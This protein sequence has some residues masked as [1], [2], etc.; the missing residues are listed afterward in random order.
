MLD[1][2]L[3]LTPEE[4]DATAALVGFNL[5]VPENVPRKKGVARWTEFVTVEEASREAVLSSKN[6]THT[7]FTLKTKV[8]PGPGVDGLN[9]GR[10]VN[11]FLRVNYGV[12]K[13]VLGAEGSNSV[14]KER[15]MSAMAINTLKQIA[16]AAGVDLAGGLSTDILDG[17][18]PE[19]GQSILVGQRL[20]V[21]VVNDENK[22]NPKSGENGQSIAQVF[23]APEGI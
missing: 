21:I 16:Q 12:L 13:G 1:N 23:V 4:L 2:D 11:E 22:P 8:V 5:R 9:V 15:I 10:N 18:F 14:E 20:A 6:A 3:N 7:V 19:A 17:L